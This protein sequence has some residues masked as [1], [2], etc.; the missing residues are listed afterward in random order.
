MW[1]FSI[2]SCMLVHEPSWRDD[3]IVVVS[4]FL[5]M[6]AALDEELA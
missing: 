2:G 3:V 5:H 6:V 4:L 1:M